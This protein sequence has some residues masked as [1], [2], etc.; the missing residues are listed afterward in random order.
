MIWPET[1]K[2]LIAYQ[3]DYV[4][5]DVSHIC[6][7]FSLA[8]MSNIRVIVLSLIAQFRFQIF[9]QMTIDAI[10]IFVMMHTHQQE[11]LAQH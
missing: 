6:K 7:S 3:F 4:S 5:L 1:S 8:C 11:V 10:N 9:L 2:Y